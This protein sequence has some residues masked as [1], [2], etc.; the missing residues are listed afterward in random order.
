[1]S[2]E[3]TMAGLLE[4]ARRMS[5]RL[6]DFRLQLDEGAEIDV[7]LQHGKEIP[8]GEIDNVDRLLGWKGRQVLLYIPDQGERI[9]DVLQDGS[10]G[11][12]FHVAWCRT[13]EEMQR[14]NRF[15]RYVATNDISQR[16]KVYGTCDGRGVEGEAELRVCK[17][18]L[19]KLN[20]KG[21]ATARPRRREIWSRF[22]LKEFF[23]TYSTLFKR[24]PKRVAGEWGDGY[25]EEWPSVSRAYREKMGWRCE[26]CG[27]VLRDRPELLHVHH[28]DGVK[29]N[30]EEE[31]LVA[32]CKDCH[33]KEPYH[34]HMRMSR[35]EMRAIAEARRKQGLN[36]VGSWRDVRRLSDLA[37]EGLIDAMERTWGRDREL[38]DV[39]M[40]VQGPD[41]VAWADLAWPQEKI[42]VTGDD[43]EGRKLR[44]W[45]WRVYR[46]G[47]VD[48]VLGM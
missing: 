45:G 21:Y 25:T 6:R 41:G 12:R 34:Q 2:L 32:L 15:E 43:E 8:L 47:D 42:A 22:D 36:R 13:L 48:R 16:F 4:V 3:R 19:E 24:L 29:S 9:W 11:R 46:P 7:Q 39:Y 20:Y 14:K 26:S 10:Q 35:D 31:N 28:R 38:P 5:P 33:R 27:V 37:L 17:N 18:C 23:S 40:A 1:M 44:A 30:N